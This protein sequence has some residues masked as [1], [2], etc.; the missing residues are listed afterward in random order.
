MNWWNFGCRFRISPAGKGWVKNHTNMC[1]LVPLMCKCNINIHIGCDLCAHFF[2]INL[3]GLWKYFH[4]IWAMNHV[5][6]KIPRNDGVISCDAHARQT[7][8]E[9]LCFFDLFRFSFAA[10]GEP[11]RSPCQ[12]QHRLR[13]LDPIHPHSKLFFV[14]FTGTMQ[15]LNQVPSVQQRVFLSFV[16]LDLH[17]DPA[18]SEPP[19][20]RQPHGGAAL[21]YQLLWHRTPGAVDHGPA[22]ILALKFI[23]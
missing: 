21:P 15:S 23:S 6:F 14:F 7:D 16:C 2:P 1:T 22:G 5:A 13:W 18:Q 10:L 19:R 20:R 9:R 3:W 4:V 8:C 11:I 12:W 17:Q